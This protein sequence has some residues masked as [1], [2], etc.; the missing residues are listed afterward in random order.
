MTRKKKNL[1]DKAVEEHKQKKVGLLVWA[2]L[3]FAYG[4]VLLQW[5]LEKT[6]GMLINVKSRL[7]PVSSI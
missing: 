5:V 4:V 2:F 6:K 1:Y 3:I 7:F